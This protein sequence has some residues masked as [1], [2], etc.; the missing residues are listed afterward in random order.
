MRMRNKELTKSVEI[1]VKH[2]FKNHNQKS[3]QRL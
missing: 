1:Y 3:S 2:T